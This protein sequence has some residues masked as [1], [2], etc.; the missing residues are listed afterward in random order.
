MTLVP[1]S[2]PVEKDPNPYLGFVWGVREYKVPGIEDA[3]MMNLYSI[4][5]SRGRV[6]PQRIVQ[7][8]ERFAPEF[9]KGGWNGLWYSARQ[10]ARCT[11]LL[12]HQHTLIHNEPAPHKEHLCGINMYKPSHRWPNIDRCMRIAPYAREYVNLDEFYPYAVVAITK[13]WGKIIEHDD[14]YRVQNAEVV[15][16]FDPYLISSW[17]EENLPAGWR[18]RGVKILHTRE[19]IETAIVESDVANESL[20]EVPEKEVL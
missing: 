17:T 12:R 13:G 9:F 6:K 18:K 14:G 10:R 5:N 7:D 1:Q 11:M 8:G 3:A 19:E 2:H 20:I 16:A 4:L 15:Y